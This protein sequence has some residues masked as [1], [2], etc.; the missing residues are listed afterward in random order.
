MFDLV[1]RLRRS[2]A[3]Q[4][5]PATQGSPRRAVRKGQALVEFGIVFSFLVMLMVG[6]AAVMITLFQT[7]SVERTV[8]EL[9]TN[10]AVQGV[11]DGVVRDEFLA[12]GADLGFIPNPATDTLTITVS[13]E[14]GE[15][16]PGL[17][18]CTYSWNDAV[19][20]N[21]GDMVNV[22][23]VS[24]I[25]FP[26][27]LEWM[28]DLLGD[29]QVAASWIG[30]SQ[31]N[32]GDATTNPHPTTSGSLRGTVRRAIDGLPLAD[33]ILT[34]D[35]GE[36]VV[37]DSE[38][39][40]NFST[41]TTGTHIVQASKAGYQNEIADVNIPPNTTITLDFRLVG[42]ARLMT[43]VLEPTGTNL[44]SD[45][46]VEAG[47][48]WSGT[49]SV[50]TG[51]TTVSHTA[52]AASADNFGMRI[53][54][55]A[56]G[57]P[58]Q[59]ANYTVTGSFNLSR[60]YLAFAWVRAPRGIGIDVILGQNIITGGN[61][62]LTSYVGDGEWMPM[63]TTW[64]PSSTTS[65]P[66]LVIR[67]SSATAVNALIDFDELM[68]ADVTEAE[69]GATVTTEDGLLATEYNSGLYELAMDSSKSHVVR[70]TNATGDRTGGTPVNL[71]GDA[72]SSIVIQMDV[73]AL[74]TW[75][76]LLSKDLGL[77]YW[78]RLNEGV[79]D[80]TN[81]AAAVLAAT[82]VAYWRLDSTGAPAVTDYKTVVNTDGPTHYWQLDEDHDNYEDW[83]RA[84]SGLVAYFPMDDTNGV[85]NADVISGNSLAHQY[86]IT[87]GVPGAVWDNATAWDG[88]YRN[89]IINEPGLV[90]YYD[91]SNGIDSSPAGN[92]CGQSGGAAPSWNQPPR[93]HEGT[94]ALFNGTTQEMDI[95]CNAAWN[96]AMSWEAW[97]TPTN[98][99]KDQMFLTYGGSTANYFR[100]FESK[101][102]VSMN[103]SG[104]QRYVAGNTTLVN[105]QAYHL[106]ATYDGSYIRIYVNGVLDVQSALYSGTATVSACPAGANQACQ[107]GR[108]YDPD[109]RAFQG[110]LDDISIYNRSMGS[111]EVG[112]HYNV[113][114]AP[115][116]AWD[117]SPSANIPTGNESRTVN[118]WYRSSRTRPGMVLHWGGSG[119]YGGQFGLAVNTYAANNLFVW[120]CGGGWDTNVNVP[121]LSDGG[122]HMLTATYDNVGNWMRLYFDGAPV[123]NQQM[124]GPLSTGMNSNGL[125]L[126]RNADS[127]SNGLD[128]AWLDDL[129]IWNNALSATEIGDLYAAAAATPR[130]IIDSSTGLVNYWALDEP[131]STPTARNLRG[132]SGMYYGPSRGEEP[133][134]SMGDSSVYFDGADDEVD[135]TGAGGMTRITMSAWIKPTNV[136]YG[137]YQMVVTYG[138]L[139]NYLGIRNGHLYASYY[140]SGTQRVLEGSTSLENGRV[141]Q[142]A[143]TYDGSNI[144]IYLDGQLEATSPTYTGSTVVSACVAGGGQPCQIGRWYDTTTYAFNGYIDEVGMWSRALSASEITAMYNA[145]HQVFVDSAG[146]ADLRSY[147]WNSDS[148]GGAT[149]IGGNANRFRDTGAK[150]DFGGVLDLSGTRPYSFEAWIQPQETPDG[151]WRIISNEGGGWLRSGTMLV[152]NS[153]GQVTFERWS[154]GGRLV[155][156]SGLVGTSLNR[157]THVVGTYDG[158]VMNL[159]LN[160]GLASTASSSSSVPV[161]TGSIAVGAT[162]ENP[163]F[164]AFAGIIDE[165]AVYNRALTPAE[166]FK[167]FSIGMDTFASGNGGDPA[168]T[169][170]TV[171][172]G[173][174]AFT[175]GGNAARDFDGTNDVAMAYVPGLAAS[176]EI[177]ITWWG[178]WDAYS[179]NDDFWFELS[180]NANGLAGAF[181]VDPNSSSG[182]FR[183][184][185]SCASGSG[186]LYT[187]ARP[188][189]T[190]WH[191]YALT[192]D[193]SQPIGSEV[194]VFV[195]GIRQTVA[196]NSACNPTGNFATGALY[197]MHRASNQTLYGD[198]GLDE[199]AVYD[200]VLTSREVLSQ[201]AS[202]S[203]ASFDDSIGAADSGFAVGVTPKVT[204][205]IAS[206]SDTAF[207]FNAAGAGVVDLPTAIDGTFTVEAWV[208]PDN[209]NIGYHSVV[210]GRTAGNQYGFN[211]SFVDGNTV[212]AY[213]GDGLGWL[214]TN[215]DATLNYQINTWYHVIY[216]VTP[217][218]YTVYID[219]VEAGSGSFSGVAKFS[220]DLQA[221]I[222]AT[223]CTPTC[224]SEN[225]F[226]GIID[227]VAIYDRAFSK[228]DVK[229]HYLVGTQ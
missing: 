212:R 113:G 137:D 13:K 97:V 57:L 61:R 173:T 131:S 149:R 37:T 75:T 221:T 172:S 6:G 190:V 102:F 5:S 157:W 154:N 104:A 22:R 11:Y 132:S 20:L 203:G 45:P 140:I 193:R 56:V 51:Q 120:G 201:V 96:G 95:A 3:S 217:I 134:T 168:F 129:A 23:I 169:E 151:Y 119:C 122:W 99:T 209:T 90:N 43:L 66:I 109:P 159:Y 177:S 197:M 210:S 52:A 110:Y 105:G 138:A 62:G 9:G 116:Y 118:I 29:P 106:V 39:N 126:G 226:G 84:K 28:N 89:M 48:G 27:M 192:I 198:G 15:C 204:G 185:V 117:A 158:S 227:E 93:I 53:S 112:E 223:G 176:D 73:D 127:V 171:A 175:S 7:W 142:I 78:W 208:N 188:S 85:S 220:P 182:N 4:P 186:V 194:T 17:T 229:W 87:Q 224:S 211:L 54:S 107:I 58:N 82:P 68:V 19:S 18:T 166:V 213:I 125:V 181:Y 184:M 115:A 135:I 30:I 202:V 94:S 101:P 32:G 156:T 50:F 146:S 167:H 76:D 1:R 162:S 183:V 35:T 44:L 205:A 124:P 189:A 165:A 46:G 41:I 218:G 42:L 36:S 128:D 100:I 200:R 77:S 174:V 33:V 139:A 133:L 164:D 10:I 225:R 219:G 153:A 163:S 80:G 196:S 206:E 161:H 24:P 72:A 144:R 141:Y 180:P 130:R 199:V 152:L 26:V 108:W 195:D 92:G 83:I 38:G 70:A 103:I 63:W 228:S 69:I 160:G 147:N 150:A 145:G 207:K 114:L 170:G 74:P 88:S 191:H 121:G 86:G 16:A 67:T 34:L 143:S 49:V 136:T 123:A 65:D 91:L 25:Q 2:P 40:Y 8:N 12:R 71:S 215:A 81:Y 155:A 64:S 111:V 148:A 216:V 47:T 178:R 98:V 21:Y 55:N 31:R 222:A 60:T 79:N 187:M 59:G 214:E 179:N 14:V